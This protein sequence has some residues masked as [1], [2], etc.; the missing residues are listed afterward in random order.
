MTYDKFSPA[1]K[2]QIAEDMIADIEGAFNKAI[3]SALQSDDAPE[4][5]EVVVEIHATTGEIRQERFKTV[6]KRGPLSEQRQRR[7]DFQH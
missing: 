5:E 4:I 3:D 6:G 2:R 7:G 1:V